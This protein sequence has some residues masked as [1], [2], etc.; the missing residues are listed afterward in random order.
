MSYPCTL[1]LDLGKNVFHLVC[2]DTSDQID[3]NAFEAR[4]V[5]LQ[6]LRLTG[7]IDL[8]PALL[9]AL[10]SDRMSA[11]LVHGLRAALKFLWH[12]LSIAPRPW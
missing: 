5:G 8:E 6:L 9:Q 1:G 12:R 2:Q 11:S 7:P 3:C 10:A 4:V